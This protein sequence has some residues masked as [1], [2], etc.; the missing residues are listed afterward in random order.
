MTVADIPTRSA[1][2]PPSVTFS[3]SI[4]PLLPVTGA[5]LAVPLVTGDTRRY[6]NLDY[7][8]SA[9]CLQGVADH[10]AEILPYYASVHRGAGF[11]SQVSTRLV[12][13]ARTT[14]KRFLGARDDDVVI[15]TRN[16]TD[17]LNLLAGCLPPDGDVVVLDIEHHADLLPWPEDRRRTVSAAPT[18]DATLRR[19]EHE[20]ARRP[21]ALLAVTGAS[22]VTGEQ[23]PVGQLARIA[24][25]HGARISV[26]AAQLAP[27]RRID[28]IAAEIDYLAFSG[29][30]LYAPWGAGVLVGR[31]DWLDA[32]TP[33]LA[34]GGA[35]RQV[36]LDH[37]AWAPAPA[38]HEAGSPNVIGIA[39]L[40][41]ACDVIASLP[42]GALETHESAL[43]DRLKQGLGALPGV[44][45]HRIWP[46][47]SS[48]VG[49]VCFS[50]V[51]FHPGFVAAYLS[52]EHGIGVRDGKF[53][54]HP[55]AGRFGQPAGALRA[56]VGLGTS[57]ADVDRLL[58]ALQELV[59]HGVRWSYGE[60]DGKCI[61]VPD[62]RPAPA[63]L[64][65]LDNDQGLASCLS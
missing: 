27:H 28:L 35:V 32:G 17:S 6:V 54:A 29:H 30:K 16:T 21:A 40:A 38:R 22:N 58:A 42:D 64:P 26:D 50:V 62:P 46:D 34:G 7:A 57:S 13:G 63:W 33:Y 41:K 45:L 53:C 5:E 10:V 48:A 47:S 4:Q 59:Q 61:P 60:I 14:V 31:R 1:V 49:I 55:L 11:A 19:V 20:L 51:G 12:E 52:A 36:T 65:D 39:A 23:L 37:T 9:P 44:E 2:L 18:L 8:A 56:S 24:H 25:R 15:F 43:R 3:H